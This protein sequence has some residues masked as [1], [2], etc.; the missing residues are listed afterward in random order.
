[1]ISDLKVEVEKLRKQ[2]RRATR[3]VG[4]AYLA[5]AC[6]CGTKSTSDPSLSQVRH[7]TQELTLSN[8][9]VL[10]YE[11][12]TP[13]PALK[14]TDLAA[15]SQRAAPLLAPASDPMVS[16]L[17]GSDQRGSVT[18][19]EAVRAGQTV[20]SA[21]P[22]RQQVDVSV[23]DLSGRNINLGE[24]GGFTPRAVTVSLGGLGGSGGLCGSDGLS[25][26]GAAAAEPLPH[27]TSAQEGT[28]LL[29]RNYSAPAAFEAGVARAQGSRFAPAPHAC[30]CTLVGQ[31]QSQS[32][33]RGQGQNQGQVQGRSQSNSVPHFEAERIIL[34]NG[35]DILQRLVQ[36]TM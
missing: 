35:R 9:I 14:Y 26:L 15:S 2:A 17:R 33:G 4:V 7:L 8:S 25:G 22:E 6:S 31:G 12:D 23:G 5:D 1:M 29:E 13:A 19:A 11:R 32:Q 28:S 16:D 24:G 18:A 21:A 20:R 3:G 27:G 10:E 34:E 36:I 30:G